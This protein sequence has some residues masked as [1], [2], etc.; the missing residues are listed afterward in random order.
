M[1]LEEFALREFVRCH[2]REAA[3]VLEHPERNGAE[4]A[5]I[6]PAELLSPLLEVMEPTVSCDLLD[7]V[8]PVVAAASLSLLSVET[9]T[10]L[11]RRLGTDRQKAVLSL[12]ERASAEPIGLLLRYPE[13]TAGALMDP[14]V[15]TLPMDIDVREAVERIRARPRH[16]FYNIYLIDRDFRLRGMVNFRDLMLAPDGARLTEVMDSHPVRISDHAKR[17]DIL[18]HPGWTEQHLLPVVDRAG[19]LQGVLPYKVIRVLEEEGMGEE[20]GGEAVASAGAALGELYGVGLKGLIKGF[21]SGL[22]G[23]K[24]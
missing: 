19:H 8:D 3:R 16:L 10:L 5:R 2:P 20:P 13:D 15:F 14:Q 21:G 23:R 7:R 6:L 9:A 1:E 12:M 17:E 18:A 4:V 22:G 11:L 24:R